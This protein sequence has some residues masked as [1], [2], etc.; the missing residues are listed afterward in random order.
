[1]R[2]L[3]IIAARRDSK[4]IPGKN[5]KLL[6]GKPLIAWSIE[7]ALEVS[8]PEDICITTNS[9]EIIDLATHTYG[10]SGP[11]NLAPIPAPPAVLFCMP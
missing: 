5:W 2:T 6:G 3:T 9:Q 7:A 10:L 8:A 1:M 4:G 11:K